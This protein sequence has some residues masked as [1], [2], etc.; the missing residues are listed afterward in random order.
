MLYKS[1]KII[2]IPFKKRQHTTIG[3][4]TKDVLIKFVL[5][6]SD[7]STK[8]GRRDLPMMVTLYNTG[9]WVQPR[10]TKKAFL[11]PEGFHDELRHVCE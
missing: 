7:I 2:G 4:L 10:K 5:E 11:C 1:Q 9:S 6:Q 3:Y 8:K